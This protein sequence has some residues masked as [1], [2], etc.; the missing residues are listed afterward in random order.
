MTSHNESE[1]RRFEAL[2]LAMRAIIPFL[3]DDNVIET[4]ETL[5]T[6]A[7][8][9]SAK[10]SSTEGVMAE[11]E[12]ITLQYNIIARC[13]SA[14]FAVLEQLHYL[15]HFYQFS[16][17]YF[18]DIFHSVLHGNPRL[19]AET[20]Y[21]VRRDIIIGDLFI[22]TFKR[23]ALG[24][25]QKDRTTLAILLAQASPHKMDRGLIDVILDD[26]V[27]GRD[28]SSE[29][30]AGDEAYARAKRLPALK[31]KLDGIPSAAWDKFLSEELAENFVPQIWGDAAEPSDAALL[32]L[33]LVKLFRLDRFVPAAERF[34]TL[35]FGSELFDI[36]EDLAGTVGQAPAT[37]PI[38]L[39]SSPGFDAS[40]KV[41]NLVERMR[42]RC[43]NIA[44]GSNEGLASADKAI[45]NAAQTG[46][47]VL[48]KNVHLAPTWLQSLEKRMEALNPHSDF[49][50][51]VSMESSP[52]IPVNL[53]RASRVLMYEQPAGV[54]ANM[55]DSMS[56]L[57]TRCAR[58]PV[59]R[60]RLHL[61]LSFLHAVVQERLRYAP[62]LGWKGFWEFNDSD[63][64]CSAFV[65]DT[66]VETVALSR[67]NI[68][69]QNI[70]WDMIRAL[71]TE[72]YGGKIDDEGDFELLRRLVSGFLTP[73][74]YDIGHKLVEG[75]GE[76]DDLVVPSGTTL[77]DFMGWIQKLPEREPPT[78]LGLPANAEKL[79]LVGLGR[80]MI[81]KLKK[82]TDLLDEGEQ[83]MVEA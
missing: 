70:P 53:L 36:A 55:R 23:T 49:R 34:V 75:T 83:L 48:V 69:P 43:T 9:I 25:L 1:A 82:V 10:M 21:N 77:P 37:R 14:V 3:D 78:Y 29:R 7:A 57:S 74:A 68:A 30:G 65:I 67:T 22:T 79:L 18:L 8:E 47:W 54:R 31:D 59:E 33:L 27:E 64:E 46:S 20:N 62:N 15:D 24:L 72:T 50:L 40:Y 51:F 13:C 66:W 56:S 16:L 63:Y 45:N 28:I 61:L 5:K 4:L 2:R 52:R 76:Q 11:V 41:D 81:Q 17:R 32:S 19:S 39:V 6:E 71:V 26:R 60:T 42:V 35:V 44:M 12:Q 73:A 80:S 58:P 38:A